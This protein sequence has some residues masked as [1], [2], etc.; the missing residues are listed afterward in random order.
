MIG[1]GNE[2]RLVPRFALNK[3]FGWQKWRLPDGH[4]GRERRSRARSPPLPAHV[5]RPARPVPGPDRGRIV[6]SPVRA[7]RLT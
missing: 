7:A 1:T 6:A 2:Q 3:Q 4:P 5:S